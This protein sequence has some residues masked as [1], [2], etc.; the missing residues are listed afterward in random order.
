MIISHEHQYL[1]VELPH[2]ASTAISR[3]LQRHYDGTPILH[4]HA[5]YHQFLQSASEEEKQCFVFSG[6]RNPMDEA[7]S[8][9][10]KYR[11]NHRG[12]YT[13]PSKL[14]QSGG[15]VTAADLRRFHFLRRT[16]ADF[17]SYF[18]KFYWLPYDNWSSLAHHRFDFTIRFETLQEDFERLLKLL[19]IHQRR[20]L[21]AANPTGGKS[22]PFRSYFTGETHQRAQWVFGPFMRKW[23]Y[24]FP[25]RWNAI[26]MR[27]VNDV[28]FHIVSI[29]RNA[30]RRHLSPK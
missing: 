11:E 30:R 3:E 21:P 26:E 28:L 27:P 23:G 22:A 15:H 4:K 29:Y 9:Y 20:A 17:G 6:I 24:T 16:G 7:V 19:G 13:D 1:F 2:T 12:N 14:K 10:F 18:L 25:P 5:Y 8:M